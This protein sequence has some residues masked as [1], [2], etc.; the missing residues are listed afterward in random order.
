LINP[1]E[2][3]IYQTENIENKTMKNASFGLECESCHGK[4]VSRVEHT[5]NTVYYYCE[6]CGW[7]R[8]EK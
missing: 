5:D 7:E 8:I 6:M 2:P 4:N 1:Q 3:S